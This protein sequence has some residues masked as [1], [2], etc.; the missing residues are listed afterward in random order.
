VLRTEVTKEGVA[1][2]ADASHENEGDLTVVAEK[3]TPQGIHFMA[4]YGRGLI[5]LA[6]TAEHLDALETPLNVYSGEV[7]GVIY[8]HPA[9][10]AVTV[11]EIPD[12]QWGEVVMACV[13]LKPG[14]ALSANDR[15]AGTE[16][17]E[18]EVVRGWPGISA[19]NV[20]RLIAF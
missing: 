12:P 9:V 3:I 14:M 13:V 1:R 4:Q 18:Q 11:F 10:R 7:E 17:G 20:V 5:C 16:S 15:S 8:K 6:M 19:S 2:A